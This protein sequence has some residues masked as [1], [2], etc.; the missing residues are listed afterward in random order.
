[1]T[2][3]CVMYIDGFNF[4]YAVKRSPDTTP[5]YLGWCDFRALGERELLDGAADLT[6][7]KYFTAPVE[8]FGSL[9][10]ERGSEAARQAV[11]MEA[12]QTIPKLEVVEGFYT[13]EGRPGTAAR[14]RSRKEKQT[15]VNI[16]VAMVVDA[17]RDEYDRALLITDDQDQIPAIRAVAGTFN[18]GVD[19]WLP[20]NQ[21][22][23][24]WKLLAAVPGVRVSRITPDMLR[25]SRLPE[26][27]ERDGRVVIAPKMW[28]AP[29][30]GA[31]PAA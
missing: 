12:V 21:D 11:W 2:Q 8:G 25:R 7:V 19:V 10:G 18:R 17:A 24:R 22:A 3:R 6:M 14:W 23:S 1:M 26:R 30:P 9:G 13:G 5:I 27:I 29:G 20:P 4:Y 15:D 31:S 28:R 16:T